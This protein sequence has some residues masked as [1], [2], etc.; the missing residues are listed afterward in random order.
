MLSVILYGRNDSHGYNLHKRGALSLNCIAEVLSEDSDE[1][2]FV[3]YNTPDELPTFPEALA[4]TLTD[5]CKQRLRILRVRPS[6]HAQFVGKTRLVALECQSRNIAARR[7]NPKNRWILSTNTDMIFCTKDVRASLSSVI[8]DLED[9]FYHL[10]RFEVPEGFWERMARHDPHAAIKA[11]RANAKDFHMNEVVYGYFDNLY[12][13]PG[14]FQLFTRQDYFDVHGF[15]ERMIHGWHADANMARRMKLFRGKVSTAFDAV[16]GYHCGHTRQATSLHGGGKRI[17]NSQATF[18][19]DITDPRAPWQA[20]TWGAPEW[21]I[22]EVRLSAKDHYFQALKAAVPKAGPA[23]T[24]AALSVESYGKVGYETEH[25]LPHLCDLMFNL[26]SNQDIFF[27]GDDAVMAKGVKAFLDTAGR[28]PHFM[29]AEEVLVH[30]PGLE[31]FDALRIP[32]EEAV[33]RASLFIIQHPSYGRHPEPQRK[34]LEWLC[35]RLLSIIVDAERLKPVSQRRRV[36]VVNGIH[37]GLSLQVETGL[38]PTS[39]P[40]SSRLRQGFVV[41]LLP[42]GEQQGY[43]PEEREL[44]LAC[45]TGLAAGD[46]PKGWE[47][48][49]LQ[50][51]AIVAQPDEWEGFGLTEA[52]AVRLEPAIAAAVQSAIDLTAE[53]PVA[54]EQRDGATNRLCSGSDW[55]NHEWIQVERRYFG[56]EVTGFVERSRWVWERISLTTNISRYFPL[57]RLKT[58]KLLVIGDEPDI[59]AA[60]LAHCG[61]QVVYATVAELA[62]GRADP[63]TWAETLNPA[64]LNI[65]PTP[66][67]WRTAKPGEAKEHF[68]GLVLS[69]PAWIEQGHDEWDRV[70]S[71]IDPLI[72]AGTPFFGSLSVQMDTLIHEGSL[73]LLEWKRLFAEDGPLGSRGFTQLGAFDDRI[74]LDTVVRFEAK[75]GEGLLPGFSFGREVFVTSAVVAATWPKALKPGWK[76]RLTWP[77]PQDRFHQRLRRKIMISTQDRA[78]LRQLLQDLAAGKPR[79]G[80]ER[81]APEIAS[82]TADDPSLFGVSPQAGAAIFTKANAVIREA[83]AR[84][85]AEPIV[86]GLRPEVRT[87]LAST[88]DWEDSH[89]L[90]RAV[91]LFSSDIAHIFNRSWWTWE[92]ISLV[93]NLLASGV[94]PERTRVLVV[95]PQADH[96]AHLVSHLRFQTTC[97]TGDELLG[98][99]D[100]S[101]DWKAMMKSAWLKP[102]RPVQF[103]RDVKADQRFDAIIMLQNSVLELPAEE[104]DA[105]FKRLE[106]L[107]AP[108]GMLHAGFRVD[109]AARDTPGAVSLAAWQDLFGKTGPLGGRGFAP[110]GKIDPRTPLDTVI[111][112]GG[113]DE[114][115][116]LPA[117]SFGSKI[118]FFTVAVTSALWPKKLAPAPASAPPQL[119]D[120]SFDPAAV[121]VPYIDEAASAGEVNGAKLAKPARGRPPDMRLLFSGW[122]QRLGG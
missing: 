55:S 67:P 97:V 86:V 99:K 18:I 103:W 44:L 87:R 104:A 98:G 53:P 1:L 21:D 16:A 19:A 15:D 110:V 79:P 89:W 111:R 66:V 85:A 25:V 26:P 109:L 10:P 63:E 45:L 78:F 31:D 51:A 4:D 12:D 58:A 102:V 113:F 29:L 82:A 52:V 2:I 32:F 56:T 39:M 27:F 72:D 96:L 20:E 50:L 69:A 119:T 11:M 68:D 35:Y 92:R 76:W 47:A 57:D 105:L 93:G 41:E 65:P 77:A 95:S 70:L 62:A 75:E 46:P 121:R 71:L 14:D 112:F 122:K 54:I 106:P 6:Y 74:P 90:T 80:W 37:N 100:A 9:G 38:A 43:V 48:L 13:G 114:D 83:I 36:I 81:M 101:S 22:E 61:Y 49:G 94:T 28:S 33:E 64:W 5:R 42:P 73:S 108:K 120:A 116:T 8:G 23:Y 24:E 107:M 7:S 117:L 3:D 30:Q 115:E 118:A 88:E 60:L 40:Y 59:V 17:E 91:G 34:M 84:S